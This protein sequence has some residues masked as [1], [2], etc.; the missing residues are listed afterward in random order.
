MTQ[1]VILKRGLY[2]RP[3]AQ[4]YTG[5]LSEAGRFNR[6]TAFSLTHPTGPD[7]PRDGLEFFTE[8]QAWE[9]APACPPEIK[10]AYLERERS[11]L[12][13]ELAAAVRM[14]EDA[15]DFARGIGRNIEK[16]LKEPS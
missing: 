5:L 11:R 7:G 9:Y 12:E 13:A 8:A 2:Y 14:A 6:K 16:F 10:V 4:G 1:Y 15:K 3:N